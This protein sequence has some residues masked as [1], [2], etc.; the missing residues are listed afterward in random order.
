[1]MIRTPYKTIDAETI[2]FTCLQVAQIEVLDARGIV[3]GVACLDWHEEE[4]MPVFRGLDGVHLL[5][6]DCKTMREVLDVSGY[7]G[8]RAIDEHTG[9][10]F[11]LDQIVEEM[12]FIRSSSALVNLRRPSSIT[13][14]KLL[15]CT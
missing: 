15:L 7:Y 6:D 2:G 14:L 8:Y 1:M 13:M 12:I 11:D 3:Q 9:A 4:Q 5:L 10:P